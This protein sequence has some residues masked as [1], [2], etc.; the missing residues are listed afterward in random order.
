MQAL[1]EKC[2]SKGDSLE[3]DVLGDRQV[4]QQHS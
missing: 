2:V 1:D 4:P 3:D